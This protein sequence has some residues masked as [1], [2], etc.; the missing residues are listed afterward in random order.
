MRAIGLGRAAA[1]LAAVAL[2]LSACGR[3]DTTTTV[4]STVTAAANG[5]VTESSSYLG[6][7]SQGLPIALSATPDQVLSITFGWRARCEDGQIHTNTIRLGGA[8][9]EHGSFVADGKLTTGGVAHVDGTLNGNT[10]SGH[11]SR[12]EG[13]AFGTDCVATGISWR[14]RAGS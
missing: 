13:S 1:A 11:L 2:A 4:T 9:I 6:R 12:S 3:G 10:A 5:A 14:A 8:A 7:T